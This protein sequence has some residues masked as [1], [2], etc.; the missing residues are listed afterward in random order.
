MLNYKFNIKNCAN[1]QT[2]LPITSYTI[3]TIGD[4][5]D[6]TILVTCYVSE[7]NKRGLPG[8]DLTVSV[9]YDFPNDHDDTG[10]ITLPHVSHVKVTASNDE[11]GEYSFLSNRYRNITI[12]TL[13]E[14]TDE[15]DLV[16]WEMYFEDGHFFEPN[17][18]IDLKLYYGASSAE[19]LYIDNVEYIDCKTLLWPVEDTIENYEEFKNAVFDNIFTLS[20][21]LKV[22]RTQTMFRDSFN[23]DEVDSPYITV[24]RPK[25]HINIPI[26][27][28]YSLN[29]VKQDVIDN[30]IVQDNITKSIP[31]FTNM[32]K[33]VYIPVIK[34]SNGYSNVTKINFNLHFREHSGENWT[35]QESDDWNFNKY[36]ANTTNNN[37]YYYSYPSGMESNQSDLLGYL[38]FTNKDVKYQHNKLQKSFL[39]LSFY[40]SPRIT[41][42]SLLATSTI[43][44]NTNQLYS[45]Y[46]VGYKMDGMYVNLGGLHDNISTRFEF[47]S[48]LYQVQDVEKLE[49]FRLSSQLSVKDKY[50]SNISSEGFYLYLWVND[51]TTEPS[52]IYMKAEFNHAGYGRTIPM[53]MPYFID[54]VDTAPTTYGNNFK[55]NSDIANDWANTN[56]GYSILRYNE[57]TYLKLKYVYDIES[58]RY[59]YY[60]DPEVYGNVNGPILNI[61][62]Y[63]ARVKFN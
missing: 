31:S 36:G 47:D 23:S 35:L 4:E 58:K 26:Q 19:S 53:M 61:N 60:I 1:E 21:F 18:L 63:E 40:D 22:R 6:N 34:N 59:V 55:L 15:D 50:S 24:I 27:E 41:D 29:A 39:R 16:Y 57:Y 38:G 14:V 2:V 17:E 44:F 32:E 3:Q 45:N 52:S 49:K 46:M 37:N 42:Q 43:F 62:L 20:D 25:V 5:L 9:T 51:E 56:N 13:S 28:H 10:D 8:E 12:T 54:G 48:N 30:V 33:Q 7:I 11:T